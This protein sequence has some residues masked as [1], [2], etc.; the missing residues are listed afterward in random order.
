M[1]P[2]FLLL[3]LVEGAETLV[4]ISAISSL[5]PSVSKPGTDITCDNKNEI[6]TTVPFEEMCV[7]L[8]NHT[9]TGVSTE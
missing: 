3:P 6:Y 2:Q 8:R 9:I 5:I 4:N 1:K 7:I